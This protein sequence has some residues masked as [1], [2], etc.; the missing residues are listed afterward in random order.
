[1]YELLGHTYDELGFLWKTGRDKN[2]N[3]YGTKL[4]SLD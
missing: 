4:I 1:M 3:I 2:V